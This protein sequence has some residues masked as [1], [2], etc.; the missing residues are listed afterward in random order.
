MGIHY[1]SNEYRTTSKVSFSGSKKMKILVCNTCGRNHVGIY[2]NV[3]KVYYEY[4]SFDHLA[5]DCPIRIG[6][7]FERLVQ[8]ISRNQRDVRE[9]LL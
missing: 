1:G 7:Q 4:R 6:G 2:W 8:A 5:R 3:T 9:G